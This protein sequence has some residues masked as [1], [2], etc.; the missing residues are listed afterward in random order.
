MIADMV[1]GDSRAIAAAYLASR[2]PPEFIGLSG[3]GLAMTIMC[4]ENANRTSEAAALAKAKAALPGFPD[5]V[6]RLQPKQGRL[7]TECPLWNVGP[8]AP[9]VSAPIVS[10]IPVLILE[11][12]FDA[13]TA[14]A[15]VDLI[16]PNLKNSQVVAFPFTGHAVLGKSAC[17]PSIMA[18]FLDRPAR[19]VDSTCA[20][21]TTLTFSR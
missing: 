16:T 19:P 5:R 20:A 3:V 10:E 9:S 7:F 13:A 1:R 6:L 2:G 14:P 4:A 18:A 11:G 12:T 21:R 17:A 8:A 15:W